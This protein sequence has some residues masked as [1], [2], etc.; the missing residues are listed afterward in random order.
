MIE[1]FITIVKIYF[2]VYVKMIV[3]ELKKLT[4]FRAKEIKKSFRRGKSEF[5]IED[6]TRDLNLAEAKQSENA[7]VRKCR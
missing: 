1:F 4:L 3:I 2:P 6:K 5:L 7:Y